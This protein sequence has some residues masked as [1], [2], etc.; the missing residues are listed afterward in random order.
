RVFSASRLASRV[1]RLSG[2][3][4]ENVLLAAGGDDTGE[5]YA[6]MRSFAGQGDERRIALAER[7]RAAFG[8]N[9]PVLD[10]YAEGCYD[11]VHLLVALAAAGVLS[12]REATAAARRLLAGDGEAEGWAC[13]P[14]GPPGAGGY[15]ARADGLDLTVITR[16]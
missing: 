2:A 4:E 15:L 8:A 10:A 6:A 1:V 13:A 11:G 5:L 3:L 12:A 16:L 7:H 14:L 9:G